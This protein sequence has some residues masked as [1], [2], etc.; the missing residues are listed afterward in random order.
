MALDLVVLAS[1]RERHLETGCMASL[2][3]ELHARG[4]APLALRALIQIAIDSDIAGARPLA[5]AGVRKE[6]PPMP[7]KTRRAHPRQTRRQQRA[8]TRTL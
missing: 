6:M 4:L 7:V 5:A 2:W 3:G 8:A 1:W